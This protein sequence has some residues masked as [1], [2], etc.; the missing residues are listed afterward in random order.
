MRT[1]CLPDPSSLERRLLRRIGGSVSS[2]ARW[3][4]FPNGE[5]FLRVEKVVSRVC[6]LGRTAPP[7]DNLFRT[8]LLTDTLRRAGARRMTL[9]IPYFG[10]ARQDRVGRR[11]DALT[12]SFITSACAAVGAARLVTLDLHSDRVRQDSP[13]VLENVSLW[14][15]LTRPF[16]RD[17]AGREHTIVAPD[18]GSRHRAR[19]FAG[20][21]S[22]R[23]GSLWFDKTRDRTGRVRCGR[24]HGTPVGQTAVIV[25]DQIDTGGTVLEAVHRLKRLGFRRFMLCVTHPLF[26]GDALR[27]VGRVFEKLVVSDSL[28]LSPGIRRQY[29]ITVIDASGPLAAAILGQR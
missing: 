27:R 18:G 14:P 22:G 25:D 2:P 15:E 20:L 9:V 17:L 23:S 12:S 21:L 16:R 6:V 11:G 1:Y 26:S 8:L 4:V 5:D 10:Y 28:P 3:K 13:I 7:G 19:E 29:G 24:H